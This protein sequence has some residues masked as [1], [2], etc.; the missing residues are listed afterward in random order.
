MFHH[1]LS[2]VKFSH[3]VFALPFALIGFHLAYV[4]FQPD[5]YPLKLLLVLLSMV[6]ARSAAMAFNRYIDRNI[7]AKNPR[8]K[9]REIPAGKISASAAFGFTSLNIIAFIVTTFFINTLCF[10][11]SPIAL[12]VI[13]GYSYTKRFTWLC[14]YIL[15]LGLALAPIGAYL[16][17][18]GSFSFLSIVLGISVFFWVA[19]FDILYALQDVPF[20]LSH[21]LK[22]I[23]ARFGMH[24]AIL[25]SKASHIFSALF[26]L[27]GTYTMDKNHSEVGFIS[28]LAATSFILLLL[29]QHSLVNA[30]DLS[31]MNQA[32]FVSNGIASLTLGF[33][34]IM[35][36][37]Y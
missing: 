30:R 1:F 11:L 8:T 28:W 19:G 17:V 18:S 7:D 15:G 23:P 20:D 35:D 31:K 33:L 13:L 37:F 9:D 10:Y 16:A 22:S 36:F 21:Q 3:T 24:K 29:R 26:L 6:F 14:H 25:I 32:F 27:L 2:L 12:L 4:K 5:N 34:M